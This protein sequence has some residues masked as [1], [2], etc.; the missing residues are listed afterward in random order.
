MWL[1]TKYGFYSV[2]EH[3]DQI[4]TLIIRARAREDLV[5]LCDEVAAAV[6]RDYGT[7]D[8]KGFDVEA[9]QHTPNADYAY[10]I[11]VPRLSWMQVSLR[12]MAE[13]SYPNFKDAVAKRDPARAT[14]YHDV[15]M[16]LMEIQR[17]AALDWKD[18][19]LDGEAEAQII[20]EFLDSSGGWR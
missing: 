13:I 14:L 4:D 9:I 2:V 16:T 15:W 10:R 1:Q 12:L 19:G 18:L 17:P 8:A 11:E 3:R 6:R 7:A 20:D 5:A